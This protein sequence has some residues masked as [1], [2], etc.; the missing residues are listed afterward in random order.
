MFFCAVAVLLSRPPKRPPSRLLTSGCNLAGV[1]VVP[2]PGYIQLPRTPDA[3]R[4]RTVS[5]ITRTVQSRLSHGNV[6]SRVMGVYL[7]R[8]SFGWAD[9]QAR[10]KPVPEDI[11][12]MLGIAVGYA[13][14]H[15]NRVL[16]SL[17]I[18]GQARNV[19]IPAR[20]NA[21]C[22]A[23]YLHRLHR[24]VFFCANDGTSAHGVGFR[25][26]ARYCTIAYSFRWQE[27]S[28]RA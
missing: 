15:L 6:R 11:Y 13:A 3:R 20:A 8:N 7:L 1:G 17:F 18:I 19:E 16:P 4:S 21:L 25:S 22:R 10:R 23:C 26:Y 2:D 5:G 9:N 14:C 12:I 28:C 27:K 24:C